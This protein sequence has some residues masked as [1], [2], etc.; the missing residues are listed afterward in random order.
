MGPVTLATCKAQKYPKSDLACAEEGAVLETKL[1][2]I[3]RERV[4]VLGDTTLEIELDY[5]QRRRELV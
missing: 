1:S 4:H 2:C 3:S 5:I